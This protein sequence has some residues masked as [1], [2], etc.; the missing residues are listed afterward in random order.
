MKKAIVFLL[1]VF[2]AL[3]LGAQ[4]VYKI[5]EGVAPGAENLNYQELTLKNV[6]SGRPLVYNVTE[7]TITV[8]RPEKE[9]NTG[10]AMIIA[11]G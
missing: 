9:I 10:A 5:Y 4:E 3:H 2:S 7:P 8:Y 6:R 11:P 1:V